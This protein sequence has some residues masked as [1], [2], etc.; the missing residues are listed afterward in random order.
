LPSTLTGAG[1]QGAYLSLI[2]TGQNPG[3]RNQTRVDPNFVNPYVE[4]WSFSVERQIS[5]KVSFESRYVGNHGVG[6]FQTI[7]GNPL[8]C[9]TFTGSTCTAGL[10]VQAPSLIPAGFTPCSPTNAAAGAGNG[11]RGRIDCN[12]SNLRIRNN[13]AWS[14][15]NGLQ[16]ELKLRNFHGLTANVAYTWSK[17]IDNVSEIFSSTGG[18]TTPIA[19]NPFNP[20]NGESGVAAQSFPHVVSTYWIYELPWMKSQQGFLGKA[21]GG[22]QFSGTHRFQSG[23]P[24]TP[25]QNTNNGDPY[26]DGGFNNSFIGATLDSCRPL[27]SNPNAPFN[28]SGRYLNATQLINVSTCQSTAL[29]GTAACPFINP[30]DVHFIVNNTFAINALCGGNPFACTAGRNAFPS[31]ARNQLDLAVAK[32]F[33]LKESLSLQLRADVF[34]ALNYQFL[35]VPGLNVNNRNINGVNTAGAAPGTFGETWANNGSQRSMTLN[36]HITF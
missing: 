31:M 10:A 12:F 7:N 36:A 33:K 21:L 4:Q 11:A 32:N 8:L 9:S 17:S 2:P 23:A 5:N 3:A 14:K 20:S 34:N 22:W 24:I 28:T 1:V 15:Y 19:Q 25:S 30:T 29:A 13:G 26:C 6:N 27:V 18:V 16:N 35:G